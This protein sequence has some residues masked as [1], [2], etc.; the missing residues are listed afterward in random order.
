MAWRR[1]AGLGNLRPPILLDARV[2]GWGA[3]RGPALVVAVNLLH[4][5]SDEAAT[6]ALRSTAEAL[7]TGGRPLDLR[8]SQI[9]GRRLR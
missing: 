6:A 7:I 8:V 5:I 9:P 4:L 1:N 3:T 2:A